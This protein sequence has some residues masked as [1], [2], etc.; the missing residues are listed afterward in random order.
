MEIIRPKDIKNRNYYFIGGICVI[1]NYIRH[2]L[3]GYRTPRT[4]SIDQIDRAIDYDFKVV[5]NWGSF[6]NDYAKETGLLK[7]KKVLELGVGPD[8]G[9]G[10]ILLAK[11]V[12]KYTALDVHEL[13]KTAPINFYKK[14][15]NRLKEMHPDCDVEYLKE[16]LNKCYKKE[17]CSVRYIVDRNFEISKIKDKFDIV[18]SQA[19]FE[20]FINVERIISELSS[21]VNDGGILITEIDLKTHTRWLRNKD[22]LNIYRYNTF[23]WDIFSFKGSL[24]RIRALEYKD[25]LKKNGWFGIKIEPLTVLAD[26]YLEKVKPSLNEKFRQLDSSE[27]KMLSIMLMAKK[28]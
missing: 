19:A 5:E 25:I 13:A 6:L 14:L 3:F 1:L 22:P 26:E 28:K 7:G 23:F 10:F 16:Q 9:T 20:H 4:F 2:K 15:F 21:V 11:G 27:M 12:K 18:F 8:L 17:D 24:N